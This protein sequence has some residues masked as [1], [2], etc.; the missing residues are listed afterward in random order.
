MD[1]RLKK[2]GYGGDWDLTFWRHAHTCKQARTHTQQHTHI[3][4]LPHL[5]SP[6]LSIPLACAQ[7]CEAFSANRYPFP[8]ELLRQRQMHAEVTAR[9]LELGTTIEAG[10]ILRHGV[11]GAVALGEGG[12]GRQHAPVG[13]GSSG[14][15]FRMS[16]SG[17]ALQGLGFHP[18]AL[19]CLLA[20]PALVSPPPAAELDAWALQVHREKAIYHTLNKMNMDHS[21]KILVAEAWL[22]A[23]ACAR[24]GEVLRLSAETSQ[25]QVRPARSLWF[26]C[27]VHPRGF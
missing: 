26:G 16:S 6:S 9:L 11:L 4:V 24:V 7:I 15:P 25:N 23:A 18:C 8:E 14:E 12:G 22:P 21:R 5:H 1:R 2:N 20:C 3:L 10:E 13:R 17:W 19:P 27:A